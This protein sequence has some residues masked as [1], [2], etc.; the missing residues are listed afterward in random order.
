MMA[1]NYIAIAC[2]GGGSHAAFTGGVLPVLLGEFDNLA[3]AHAAGWSGRAPAY[4][5]PGTAAGT[6]AGTAAP[7]LVAISGTSG[8][9]ISALLGW[10]GFITGGAEEA[11][12]RLDAFWDSNAATHW[13]EAS[14]NHYAR[15]MSDAASMFGLDVKT[16]PYAYPMQGLEWF[17]TSVWPMIAGALGADNPWMRPDY[18]SLPQL[19]C[20]G[21]DWQLVRAYG[22]F[23]SIPLDVQ[24]WVRS[25]LQAAMF[26]PDAPC[27]QRYREERAML[28]QAISDKLGAAQRVLARIDQ[29][30]LGDSALLRV[31]FRQWRAPP[32]RFEHDAL[33][34]LADAVGMVTR[35]IPRLLIGAVEL[36]Q[37]DFMAFNSERA[38]DDG[39]ISVDAVLASAAVPWLFRAR[40]MNGMDQDTLAARQLALW[41]GLFSQNPPVKDFLAGVMDVARKPDEIWVVQ[42]NPTHAK[43]EKTRP[44]AGT[45]AATADRLVMQGS[46]IWDLRNALAGNLS[47]NQEIGFVEAINRR[48]ESAARLAA[49]RDGD[50][51]QPPPDGGAASHDRLVQ[52][53]RIV[54]DG[55]AIE[56]ATGMDLGANSK[57][58]R[59]PRLKA[60]LCEHGRVQAG[61]Y[62]RLRRQVGRLCGQLGDTLAQAGSSAA[63]TDGDGKG[64]GAARAGNEACRAAIGSGA[65]VID[66]STL[67]S[68]GVADPAAPRALVRWRA[69]DAEVGGHPVRIE[70]RSELADDLEDAGAWRVKAVTITAAA[71][72]D[73]RGPQGTASG[74]QAGIGR[75][76]IGAQTG[77]RTLGQQ[78]SGQQMRSPNT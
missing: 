54:M 34:A 69:V 65:L 37:G 62:L 14:L 32:L 40:L 1:T 43:V 61:R 75:E 24:R 56:A 70:G 53:D 19:L 27:Q 25:D 10:Y 28:E 38:Q 55:D 46:E 5:E 73:D 58:D 42:I 71:R 47:L 6:Q 68:T 41:D 3:L 66:G 51:G 60:A 49:R 78:T 77:Q 4:H 12:R 26:P 11:G 45:P 29:L 7:V 59:D 48:M 39:G 72:K 36:H 44:Q 13:L 18:F 50:A 35:A 2:Q 64:D 52:V 57:L 21:V 17:N 23:A 30:G 8:G 67:Y 31:A 76:P 74:M 20:P 33:M 9:A 16:S 15:A 22:D 63:A